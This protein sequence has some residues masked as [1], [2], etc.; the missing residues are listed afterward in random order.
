MAKGKQ[1]QDLSWGKP[2]IWCAPL[3]DG[4]EGEWFELPT[5]V[6]GSTTLSVTKGDKKEA[7]VEGGDVECVKYNKNTYA[8]E[9]E[10]RGALEDGG[11]REKPFVDDDGVI[12]GNFALKL[13]P[14]NP[15]AEGI[16]IR[17]S[18]VSFEPSYSSEDGTK[19]KYT[20]DAIRTTGHQT[21]E[22]CKVDDPTSDSESESESAP[23][24]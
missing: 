23:A 6:E 22:F 8:L 20:F 15:N 21:C 14:E 24:A 12:A 9:L 1:V 4:V 2:K 11:I 17:R 18:K 3:V 16:Y 7:K 19:W 5:P 13:Q 10:I